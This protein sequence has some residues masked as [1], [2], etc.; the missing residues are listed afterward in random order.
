MFGK[1]RAL[2]ARIDVATIQIAER[3]YMQTEGVA[4]RDGSP[5]HGTSFRVRVGGF[6]RNRRL[7]EGATPCRIARA[8]SAW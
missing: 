8:G 1:V 2:C 4:Q 5:E 3:K 6:S 7:C